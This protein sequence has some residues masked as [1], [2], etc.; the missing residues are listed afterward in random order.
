MDA[1]ESLDRVKF[2]GEMLDYVKSLYC[3]FSIFDKNKAGMIMFSD[4]VRVVIPLAV[5]TRAEWFAAVELV[6][7]QQ[8]PTVCCTPTAE[9]FDLAAQ[10]FAADADPGNQRIGF[11]LTD[12][13]PYQ[14]PTG[15]WVHFFF[16]C[17]RR[18]RA[19]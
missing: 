5:Y 16:F 3:A 11:V 7:S 15:R 13:T 8:L 14:N 10:V 18:Q 9:A 6:R 19:H 12:G 17:R 4:T 1:S 2:N